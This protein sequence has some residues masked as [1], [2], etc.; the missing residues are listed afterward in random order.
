MGEAEIADLL[1]SGDLERVE[2]DP[3]TAAREIAAATRH[4]ESASRLA[5]DDPSAG[6]A[7][8]YDAVRKAVTAHMRA[9]G[10]RVRTTSG[11]HRRIGRYA[12]AALDGEDIA[13]H[14][15]AF[16]Q[17]RRLRNQSQ[18]DGLE[19]E[20]SEVREIVAHARAI[21][22]AVREDLAR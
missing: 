2:A 5:E 6:F 3:T 10:L 16:D 8:G 9:R 11:H 13:M 1:S 7:I 14:V 4:V 19:V 12:V 20:P 22:A 18:Y 17:L 15:E 21:V